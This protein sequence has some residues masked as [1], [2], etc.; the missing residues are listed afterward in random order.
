MGSQHRSIGESLSKRRMNRAN[1]QKSSSRSPSA[2]TDATAK[3]DSYFAGLKDQIELL[4][5]LALATGMCTAAHVVAA[6]ELGALTRIVGAMTCI[7]L[8]V[9][10]G[11]CGVLV[12]FRHRLKLSG[13]PMRQRAWRVAQYVVVMCATLFAFTTAVELAK[14]RRPQRAIQATLIEQ[15]DCTD[16]SHGKGND[17]PRR[18][19]RCTYA[20]QST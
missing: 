6:S 8:G 9:W 16:A 15:R 20:T 13:L 4:K 18:R 12:Y 7:L 14:Q 11:V 5:V 1:T 2:R 17:R 19:E 3:E 10:I